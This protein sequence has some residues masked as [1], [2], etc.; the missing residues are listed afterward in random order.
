MASGCLPATPSN[1]SGFGGLG[2]R[3]LGFGLEGDKVGR[4][5]LGLR[6]LGV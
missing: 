3:G 5:G 2:F 4:A 6:W 1:K